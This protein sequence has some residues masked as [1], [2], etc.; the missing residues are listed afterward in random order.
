MRG[1]ERNRKGRKEKGRG[2]L[3]RKKEKK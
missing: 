1:E 3:G 2:N